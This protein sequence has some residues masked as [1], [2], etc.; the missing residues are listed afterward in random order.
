[1]HGEI[2]ASQYDVNISGSNYYFRTSGDN[3]TWGRT[4]VGDMI[5]GDHGGFVTV[6]TWDGD[7]PLKK[8]LNLDG[9]HFVQIDDHDRFAFELNDFTLE[10]WVNFDS[11]GANHLDHPFFSQKDGTNHYAFS[12][13]PVSK[14]MILE[15]NNDGTISKIYSNIWEPV[16]GEFN[17]VALTRR[18]GVFNFYLNGI[19]HGEDYNFQTVPI[20]NVA[21]TLNVGSFE[22]EQVFLMVKLMSLEFGIR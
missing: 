21:G 19:A 17:H 12:Y 20:P 16:V 5:S 8:S 10:G 6:S 13:D 4:S 22:E 7:I 18:E 11:I 3:T 2:K 9:T 15:I 14:R 1:M